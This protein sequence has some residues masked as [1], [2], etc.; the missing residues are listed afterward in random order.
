MLQSFS[1]N[2]EEANES[3]ADVNATR[4]SLLLP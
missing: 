3:L 1:H 2:N 4:K